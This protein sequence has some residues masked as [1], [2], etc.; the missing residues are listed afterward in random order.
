M[1]GFATKVKRETTARRAPVEIVVASVDDRSGEP[2]WSRV[3]PIEEGGVVQAHSWER[4]VVAIPGE[5]VMWVT[6]RHEDTSVML[7][8]ALDVNFSCSDDEPPK[9]ML[10]EPPRAITLGSD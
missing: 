6:V 10:T 4:R 9:L 3:L 8:I 1:Y 5:R 7:G 2:T